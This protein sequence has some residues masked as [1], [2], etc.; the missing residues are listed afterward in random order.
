VRDVAGD[1]G[2]D[3]EIEI[4]EGG[5][6]TGEIIK[7]Q[8]KGTDSGPSKSGSFSVTVDIEKL[9]YWRALSTPELQWHQ[10]R[11]RDDVG[12]DRSRCRNVGTPPLEGW[13]TER[14]YR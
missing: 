7:V 5:K 14:G 9:S 3:L 10:Q 8:L 13:P 6:A 12:R 11:A 2:I 1:Y 4:F